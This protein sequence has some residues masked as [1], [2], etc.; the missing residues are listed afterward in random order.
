MNQLNWSL[1]TFEDKVRS[2]NICSTNCFICPLDLHCFGHPS[3]LFQYKAISNRFKKC[4]KPPFKLQIVI[5]ASEPINSSPSHKSQDFEKKKNQG[6]NSVDFSPHLFFFYGKDVWSGAKVQ[7]ILKMHQNLANQANLKFSLCQ[8]KTLSQKSER[9][10]TGTEVFVLVT[11]SVKSYLP[12][13]PSPPPSLSL[14]A[15][16]NSQSPTPFPYSPLIPL[17]LL[18]GKPRDS[19]IYCWTFFMLLYSQTALQKIFYTNREPLA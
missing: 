1:T 4:K 8:A 15:T 3:N 13:L 17:P 16:P 9:T 7:I 10:T 5:Q 18:R 19:L 11:T 6:G 14:F 2:N 12:P